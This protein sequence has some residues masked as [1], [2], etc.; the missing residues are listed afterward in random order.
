MGKHFSAGRI[1]F[2]AAVSVVVLGRRPRCLKWSLVRAQT[3]MQEVE[4]LL[5]FQRLEPRRPP[6]AIIKL[7]R[8]A[9][10]RQRPE[11]PSSSGAAAGEKCLRVYY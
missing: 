3:T 6:L 4:L 9:L 8:G 2:I 7:L 1:L 5:A 11:N 10:W